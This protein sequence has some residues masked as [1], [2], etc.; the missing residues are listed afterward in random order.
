MCETK[1][2]TMKIP[3]K[4]LFNFF[5]RT[6]LRQTDSFPANLLNARLK[7]MLADLWYCMAI[8]MPFFVVLM[9]LFLLINPFGF[10]EEGFSYSYISVMMIPWSIM[11]F[12]IINKDIASG[13]SAG[14]RV[15]GF[16][17]VDFKTKENASHIQCMLRNITMM[18]W[19]LEVL[20]VGLN[21][22][23]RIGDFVAHTEV[24][25]SDKLEVE[26]LSKDLAD[27]N[28]FS[29]QLIMGSIFVI[30]V[31]NLVF[32]LHSLITVMIMY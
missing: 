14:K 15:F 21:P 7:T 30:M 25:K 20:M 5:T 19:P 10:S 28:S 31:L 24:V 4:L 18:I 27:I 6:S 13:R 8:F 9:I 16:K 1:K 2:S 12:I 17:I 11:L 26:T 29:P 23:R 22:K 32:F 3:Q